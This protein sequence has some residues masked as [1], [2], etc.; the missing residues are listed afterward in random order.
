MVED[1]ET[2]RINGGS[3]HKTDRKIMFGEGPNVIVDQRKEGEMTVVGQPCITRA[4]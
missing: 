4:S 2:V 3:D 1:L